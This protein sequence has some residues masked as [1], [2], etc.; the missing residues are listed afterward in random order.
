MSAGPVEIKI[1]QFHKD[2]QLQITTL[3]R[4]VQH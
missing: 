4:K 2:I 3:K 1:Y